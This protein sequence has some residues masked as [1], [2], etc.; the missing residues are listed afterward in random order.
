MGLDYVATELRL[1][2]DSSTRCLKA[3][4]LHNGNKYSSIPIGHFVQMKET[5]NN[6][7]QFLSALNCHDPGWLICEDL[8]V[9]GLLLGL[10]GGYTKY[11]CFLC[12]WD[13]RAV[14]QH[15]V[16]QEW[17]PRQGLGPGLHNVQS[18]PLAESKKIL[19]PP[20]HIKLGLMKNLVKSMDREDR[21][22]TFLQQQFPR[23]SLEKLKAGI[24][25]GPEIRGLIK[26]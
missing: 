6:M 24:F 8:K 20:L 3:I 9:V 10:Q 5:H 26:D 2:I 25:D 1:F 13:S 19:L 22:F 4:L 12:L 16:R 18:C 23:I 7:D 11:P 14:G 17:T 21:G 15:Y